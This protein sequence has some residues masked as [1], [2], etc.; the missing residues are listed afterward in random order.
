LGSG[1]TTLLNNIL[2]N[3]HG[4]RIAVIV[5]DIGE[6]NID[7]SLIKGHGVE[8]REAKLVEMSNGCICCTLREDLLEE[9]ATLADQGKFDYLV[10]E[11]T[12]VSE[13]MPVAQTFSFVSEEGKA[14]EDITRLDNMVT[15]VDCSTFFDIYREGKT[16]KESNQEVNEEDDRNLSDL[17][18]EQIEFA[19]TIL[20][21]K[22][23]LVEKEE[24][25]QIEALIKQL[26]PEAV[27]YRTVNSEIEITKII[28]TSLFDL[29]KTS[30]SAGWIRELENEHTSE[31]E[32]Y[33]IKTFVYKAKK[34]FIAE[35]FYQNILDGG[36]LSGVIRAKGFYW[37]SND[38]TYIYEFSQAG[39][40][41]SYGNIVGMWWS[42][43]NEED[44]PKDQKEVI[45]KQCEQ[46]NGDRRQELVFIGINMNEEKI[47]E[48]L[49][50]SLDKK[51]LPT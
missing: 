17:L 15:V 32:E 7:A 40:N 45:K 27:I 16:L 20:I 9:V 33:G 29:D 49:D 44:W 3:N 35:K 22:T 28:N 2:N 39:K 14:L 11:S 21:N 31:T 36:L 37:L 25:E 26:N 12:G 34:P 19:N 4:L 5:N 18:T 1:K 24:I 48:Q 43:V 42:A 13:P 23:D 41:I 30:R 6:V 47:R 50:Q 10:I 38:Q 51:I 46:E 8:H